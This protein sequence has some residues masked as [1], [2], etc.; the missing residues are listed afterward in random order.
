MT[1]MLLAANASLTQDLSTA[2]EQFGLVSL[3]E[4]L[5]DRF[6][7]RD[8]QPV[9]TRYQGYNQCAQQFGLDPAAVPRKT[10]PVYN[11]IAVW[12]VD[13]MQE[14]ASDDEVEELLFI[15]DSRITDA[16]AFRGMTEYSGWTGS[17]FICDEDRQ[18]KAKLDWDE[19][20]Q[21]VEA[22]RWHLLADWIQAMRHN[23]LQLNAQTAV[24]VDIDKTALGARG[25]NDDVID[26]ARFASLHKALRDSLDDFDLNTFRTLY[27]TVNKEEYMGLTGDNQD[28]IIY[29]CL[30]ILCGELTL[31]EVGDM[32]KA[33]MQF[34]Q[35]VR[36]ISTQASKNFTMQMRQLHDQ[37]QMC[38]KSGD[39]TPFKQFR[40]QE[41]LDTTLRMGH[42]PEQA[43]GEERLQQELCITQEVRELCLWLQ[44]RGCLLLAL[45]DKP[46]EASMPHKRWHK[47]LM[48]IHRTSTHAVG[49]SIQ[50]ALAGID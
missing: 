50:G 46:R 26:A 39:R 42:L 14:Q 40:R 49:I 11:K 8:L 27:A 47:G 2:M 31:R 28:Y 20:T 24:I 18:T 36:W 21:V 15:G 5:D 38:A 4:F 48:P 41:F 1:V 16:K 30:M 29:I 6:V 22:N 17:C 13:H 7:Y 44:E 43:S 3:S 34:E 37:Y 10:D 12:I 32:V 33:N 45:S 35:V 9:D 23:N 25:R 19:K